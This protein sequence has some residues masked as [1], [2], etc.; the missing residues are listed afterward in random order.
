MATLGRIVFWHFDGKVSGTLIERAC[1][2]RV[3][4]EC[5]TGE[6]LTEWYT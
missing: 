2:A 3:G 5:D 1:D 6:Q 4:D